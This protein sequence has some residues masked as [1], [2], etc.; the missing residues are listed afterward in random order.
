MLCYSLM[1]III[2]SEQGVL[3]FIIVQ[4]L[5]LLMILIFKLSVEMSVPFINAPKS[6]I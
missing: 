6:Y 5:L 4:K 1:G 3:L 2:L